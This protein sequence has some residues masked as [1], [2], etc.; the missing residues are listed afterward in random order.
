M[1]KLMIFVFAL[2][3]VLCFAACSAPEEL[4][5]EQEENIS[6][7]VSENSEQSE[8]S[9]EPV[10]EEEPLPEIDGE[11]ISDEE[12]EF[13]NEMF[14][15]YSM[16]ENGSYVT[17]PWSHFFMSYYD[18][19]WEMNFPM[20]IYYFPSDGREVDEKEFQKL[21]KVEAWEFDSCETL[22][23]MPVPVRSISKK[24]VDAV[25]KEYTGIVTSDDLDTSAVAYLEEYDC[26][27][28][29]TSDYGPGSFNCT[30]GERIGNTLYLYEESEKGTDMLVLLEEEDSYKVISHQH[31]A[32]P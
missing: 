14:L 24:E 16:D 5:Q 1:K 2:I 17:N 15:P 13:F 7:P 29:S 6:E 32:N 8:E 31:F 20:F 27:Y 23:D 21:C 10:L 19:V 12:I 22:D 30:G 9:S 28:N 18:E 3:L 11:P 4:Q 26:Y 25:L